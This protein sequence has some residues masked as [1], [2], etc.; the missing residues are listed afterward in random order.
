MGQHHMDVCGEAGA[1]TRAH[2]LRLAVEGGVNVQDAQ[3][4][5]DRIAEQAGHFSQ[6]AAEFPLRRITVQR[7]K[8]NIEVCRSLVA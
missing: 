4:I 6:L 1:V 5:M 8:K 2:L 7:V 3:D